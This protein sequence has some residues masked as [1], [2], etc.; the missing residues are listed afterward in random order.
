MTKSKALKIIQTL[1]ANY[2]K[3]YVLFNI[4]DEYLFQ[5]VATKNDIENGGV[6][7]YRD[8]KQF[9]RGAYT[10]ESLLNDIENCKALS[11]FSSL[12]IENMKTIAQYVRQCDNCIG[13]F[14]GKSPVSVTFEDSKRKYEKFVADN[15]EAVKKY[16]AKVKKQFYG[17][18][19]VAAALNSVSN[20]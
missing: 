19:T 12:P 14:K 17:L 6:M 9:I 5:L 2:G 8:E 15:A 20:F 13:F 11:D 16:N 10:L 1:I 3:D 4:C 7:Y 18:A